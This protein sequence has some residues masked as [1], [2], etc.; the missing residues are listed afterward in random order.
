MNRRFTVLALTLFLL[1][2][3][4]HSQQDSQ[5]APQQILQ[6]GA[7]AAPAA[8]LTPGNQ[9]SNLISVLSTSDLDVFIEDPSSDAWLARNATSF[10]DRGQYTITVVSFYKTPHPCHEDQIRAGFS[11]AAHMQACDNDR[12][13]VR[14]I[15]V[16][17]PQNTVTVLSSA[18]VSTTGTLDPATART[19]TRSRSFADLGPDAQKALS[20]ATKL[21]A[22]QVHAYAIRQHLTP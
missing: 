15:S 8:V 5:P 4:A 9:W 20:A 6:T 17:A 2:C 21:V 19:E 7:L 10:L 16:D 13:A 22:T 1:C 12:Y 11:D 14:R 3:H 18:L